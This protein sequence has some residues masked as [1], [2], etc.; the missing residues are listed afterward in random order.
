LL[1]VLTVSVTGTVAPGLR[2]TVGV[3]NEAEE[4]ALVQETLPAEVQVQLP[5][6]CAVNRLTLP[7]KLL[8]ALM[9]R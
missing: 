5:G 2:M 1:V 9:L 4:P 3:S 8:L 6:K 7:E